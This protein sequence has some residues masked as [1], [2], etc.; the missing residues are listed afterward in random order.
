MLQSGR[1]GSVGVHEIGKSKCVETSRHRAG[2]THHAA[3]TRRSRRLHSLE[4]LQLITTVTTASEPEKEQ[5][6][7]GKPPFQPPPSLALAPGPS[8]TGAP[9]YPPPPVGQEA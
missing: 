1:L 4:K 3:Q 8:S 6:N 9:W 7:L 5:E 2:R